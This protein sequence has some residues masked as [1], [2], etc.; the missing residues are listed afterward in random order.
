MHAKVLKIKYEKRNFK[1]KI[2]TYNKMI[3]KNLTL[4]KEK[5]NKNSYVISL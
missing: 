4:E 2:M 3:K 1:L 5:H